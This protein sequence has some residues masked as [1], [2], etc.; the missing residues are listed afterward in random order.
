MCVFK[1]AF[2]I[3]QFLQRVKEGW[4]LHGYARVVNT[5][6]LKVGEVEQADVSVVVKGAL[7]DSVCLSSGLNVTHDRDRFFF[8]PL[9]SELRHNFIALQRRHCDI[10]ALFVPK[11]YLTSWYLGFSP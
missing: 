2:S 6:K 9:Q 5:V 7:W 11:A 10:V 1:D 8:F 3:Q 4:V